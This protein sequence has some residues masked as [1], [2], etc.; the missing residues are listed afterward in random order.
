MRKILKIV[1]IILLDGILVMNVGC[2][3]KGSRR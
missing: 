1:S 2:V 3:R